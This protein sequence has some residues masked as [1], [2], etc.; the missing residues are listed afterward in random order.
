CGTKTELADRFASD[1]SLED[2]VPE[3]LACLS[4]ARLLE[5]GATGEELAATPWTSGRAVSA[6]VIVSAMGE[7]AWLEACLESLVAVQY[8]PLQIVVV[9]NESV[10]ARHA[11]G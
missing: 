10:C 1:A 4:E 5:R 3:A 11:G 8:E 6:L 9:E 2:I 7:L